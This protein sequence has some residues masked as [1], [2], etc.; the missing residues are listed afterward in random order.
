MAVYIE[1]EAYHRAVAALVILTN[2]DPDI[3]K[4]MLGEHA[5]V[6]PESIR[7]AD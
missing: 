1:T 4:T 5:N 6:W 3:I 2:A 7:P